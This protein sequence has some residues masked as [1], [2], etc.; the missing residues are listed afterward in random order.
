MLNKAKLPSF[1][2]TIFFVTVWVFFSLNSAYFRVP[3]AEMLRWLLIGILVFLALLNSGC[4]VLKPPT[5]ICVFL[6]AT[7]P[8]VLLSVDVTESFVKFMSF[9]YVVWGLYVF[10]QSLETEEDMFHMLTLVMV[11][12]LIFEF[13]SIIAIVT[14]FGYYNSSRATGITT[15]A[16]TLGIYSDLSF[17]AS[18][19]FYIK[20]DKCKKWFF[21][22]TAILSV[23]TL[24]LSASRGA[25]LSFAVICIAFVFLRSNSILRRFLVVGC[26]C[27]VL[28]LLF[29]GKLAFLDIPALD[30]LLE[31]GGFDRGDI[32]DVGLD[33]WRTYPVFGCGY[34]MSD[35]FNDPP[36]LQ[37]HNSYLTILAETGIWGVA[38]LGGYS[39]FTFFSFV[40]VYVNNIE[41]THSFEVLL[42]ILIMIS[43]LIVAYGESFLFAVGS[44]EACL[45][46][47]MFTWMLVYRNKNKVIYNKLM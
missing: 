35:L 40:N 20:S 37:F 25:F 34:S 29:S 3:F 31:E 15:N 13:Q 42:C 8:S 27:F 4:E 5:M 10:F 30:R 21:I 44:T 19:Y 32:W 41:N 9:I 6:I 18:I 2:N 45:F 24:L 33:L 47:M 22:L 7:F 46:W 38:V 17:A 36:G 43:E 1:Q 14:G 23:W 26:S 16:N 12:V 39:V 28:Y 11:V